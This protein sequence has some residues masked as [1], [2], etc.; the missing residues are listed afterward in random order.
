MK[1]VK[2]QFLKSDVS[3]SQTYSNGYIFYGSTHI[4]RADQ[5]SVPDSSYFGTSE[6]GGNK[7]S[8]FYN[9]S[10]HVPIRYG[11]TNDDERQIVLQYKDILFN[12]SVISKYPWLYSLP[13]TESW[14]KLSTEYLESGEKVDKQVGRGRGEIKF[15]RV[16]S[17][18][19]G[20]E[21]AAGRLLTQ[22]NTGVTTGTLPSNL[23]ENGVIYPFNGYIYS[24]T[25]VQFITELNEDG[26]EETKVI[27]YQ[28]G[29]GIPQY[30]NRYLPTTTTPITEFGP[31]GE[32]TFPSGN[33]IHPSLATG[34]TPGHNHACVGIVLDTQSST[35]PDRR[36]FPVTI[37]NGYTRSELESNPHNPWFNHPAPQTS[38]PASVETETDQ[39][40]YSPG[41]NLSGTYYSPWPRYYAYQTNEPIPVLTSGITT[42]RIGAAYNIAQMTYGLK[43]NNEW[44]PVTC[45]PLFQGERIEAGSL[46][47]ASVKGHVCTPGPYQDIIIEED[48]DNPQTLVVPYGSLGQTPWDPFADSTWGNIGWAGTPGL[49]FSSIPD[50]GVGIPEI[51]EGETLPYLNQSNQGTVIVQGLTT[52][53]PSPSSGNAYYQTPNQINESGFTQEEIDTLRRKRTE[54]FGISGRC[55]LSQTV[56]ERAQPIGIVIE[57]IVG[58]GQ[59]SYTGLPIETTFDLNVVTGGV[60][61]G[62]PLVLGSTPLRTNT[63]IGSGGTV[64]WV[65]NTP[66]PPGLGTITGTLTFTPGVDYSDG[67]ILTIQDDSL[68]WNFQYHGNNSSVTVGDSATTLTL[69]SGGSG[70]TVTSAFGFNLSL[71]NIY[72][73]F[74][75]TG[76]NLFSV[77]TLVGS[78]YYQDFF[79]Y[80][81]GTVLRVFNESNDLYSSLAFFEIE[82]YPSYTNIDIDNFQTSSA[83]STVGPVFMET[84]QCN[85]STLMGRPELNILTI[86][87]NG[88]IL[89]Y[90]IIDYGAGN[91]KGD[92]ILV[93]D[94]DQN[95][96]IEFPGFQEGQQ[97]ITGSGLGYE[98]GITYDTES[99]DGTPSATTVTTRTDPLRSDNSPIIINSVN[100]SIGSELLK[101]VDT[102]FSFV[103]PMYHGNFLTFLSD[104]SDNMPHRGG[105]NYTTTTKVEC[106]NLTANVFRAYLTITNQTITGASNFSYTGNYSVTGYDISD[107]GTQVRILLDSTSEEYQEIRRLTGTS[108][109]NNIITE[110]TKPGGLYDLTD[111]DYLFQTQ[112]LDQTNPVVDITA[113]S[114]GYVRQVKLRDRGSN[115]Q[116]GDYIL[117]LAGDQNCVFR[118]SDNMPYI[119]LPPYARV[120][121]YRTKDDDEAW[122]R[123]SNIMSTAVNLM[124]YPVL[125]QLRE[126]NDQPME[127]IF[128]NG[129]I[130]SNRAP[131]SSDMY[132]YQLDY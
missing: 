80:P 32:I 98:E 106:Y 78:D 119:D 39:G 70:Y 61:Y 14:S 79:K 40:F 69:Q 22:T 73:D 91:Q 71:N 76:G 54:M 111:G 29:R 63:G 77:G 27:P 38:P 50:A 132:R 3:S 25:L 110:V 67:D 120:P 94:G 82:D 12:Y 16:A 44:L 89:T 128:P 92:R 118:F 130:G 9:I 56:P 81:V 116:E 2:K 112:R 26:I 62:S 11:T 108:G 123:Y 124:D 85:V 55:A 35:V 13:I 101:I 96:V 72:L 7:I 42:A 86:G 43:V 90:E 57:T 41:P 74:N 103:E 18:F 24:G 65:T 88:E 131:P 31:F 45:I 47:Y 60:T 129:T 17:S 5:E 19:D 105:T 127:N 87:S 20:Q 4:G 102:S 75:E 37:P 104:V 58:T 6:K 93:I 28:S 52:H 66:S 49:S 121:E 68:S 21:D 33:T 97:E 107:T 115:N 30:S 15:F 100:P 83:Y 114:N 125:I 46:V 122:E 8:D 99:P 53:S 126:S 113:D 23:L 51:L 59:W 48:E 36:I 1:S 117:V 64:D 10:S 34:V 109:G 84:E 95:G